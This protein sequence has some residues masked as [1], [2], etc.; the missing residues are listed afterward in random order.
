MKK[1]VSETTG[2]ICPDCMRGFADV[3]LLSAHFESTHASKVRVSLFLLKLTSLRTPIRT[4]KSL[5]S[6]IL[7]RNL[8]TPSPNLAQTSLAILWT[9]WLLLSVALSTI[10][11]NCLLPIL[12]SGST[13]FCVVV[14]LP[15]TLFVMF[16]LSKLILPNTRISTKKAIYLTNLS[17]INH[18]SKKI[19]FTNLSKTMHTKKQTHPNRPPLRFA[20]SLFSWL[21]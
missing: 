2:F 17:K 5:D 15:V 6:S 1:V 19:K 9:S 14:L 16:N 21:S 4:P 3:D 18:K 7:P 12:T 11:P 10:W 20:F 13:L 8:S